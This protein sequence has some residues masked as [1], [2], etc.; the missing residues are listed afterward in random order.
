MSSFWKCIA[1]MVI[2]SFLLA[3]CERV[4]QVDIKDQPLR[5]VVE[6][7]LTDDSTCR[8][9]LSRTSNFYD[10][11]NLVGVTGAKIT[12]AEDG[13]TPVVLNASNNRGEYRA[14]FTGRPGRTY[15]LRIEY[16][17]ATMTH[18]FTA[19]STMPQ[20]VTLD[21]LYVSE[22]VFL[23]KTRMMAA[24]RFKDPPAPGNAYRYVQRVDGE[25]E[26]TVFV[27]KDDLI[28]GRTVVDE[29]LIFN[30]DYTLKNATS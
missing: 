18:V 3:A 25:L 6:G 30:D 5:F 22:R 8:V 9:R 14:A 29:L 10:T 23:G 24:I 17:D 13:K 2:S 27:T 11:I 16:T 20:K 26:T 12:I 1:I 19:S 15:Q 7:V 21:S 4:I 28:N